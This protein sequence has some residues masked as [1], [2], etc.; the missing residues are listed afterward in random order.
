MTLPKRILTWFFSGRPSKYELSAPYTFS[1]LSALER[2]RFCRRPQHF[3]TSP[4][5]LQ[6]DSAIR[7]MPKTI[8]VASCLLNREYAV[9]V[10]SHLRF[11]LLDDNILLSSRFMRTYFRKFFRLESMMGVWAS[12]FVWLMKKSWSRNA[13]VKYYLAVCVSWLYNEDL[14][15]I[16]CVLSLRIMLGDILW[17]FCLKTDSVLSLMKRWKSMSFHQPF[18]NEKELEMNGNIK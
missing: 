8:S 15:I 4:S 17:H 13:K 18:A 5:P 10:A 7:R 6:K 3:S 11:R 1:P 12:V 16:F 2:I 9:R 14:R